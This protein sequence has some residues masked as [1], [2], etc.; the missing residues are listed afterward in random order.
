VKIPIQPASVREK[1]IKLVA[2]VVIL[3]LPS[4]VWTS[5]IDLRHT[6]RSQLLMVWV[7]TYVTI[8]VVVGLVR[9]RMNRKDVYNN[10]L[11]GHHGQDADSTGR[12][13]A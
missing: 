2:L 10:V 8:G 7:S 4:F 5:I 1:N 9:K 3:A 6:P 11:D 12:G 13:S